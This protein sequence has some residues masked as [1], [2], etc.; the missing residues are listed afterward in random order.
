M[1]TPD[2]LMRVWNNSHRSQ[3]MH[4]NDDEILH[5]LTAVDVDLGTVDVG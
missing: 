5:V 1:V 4:S 2:T 3:Y